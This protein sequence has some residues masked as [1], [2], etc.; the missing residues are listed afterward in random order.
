M[1]S[2]KSF[3]DGLDFYPYGV[4][5]HRA[6]TPLKTEWAGDMREISLAGYTHIQL[7]PQWKW[8]ERIHGKITW[9]DMDCL[10]DLAK[11]NNLRVVLKPM[12]ETAPDWVFS[13][14]DGTRMG[15][16]GIAIPPYSHSAYY[17]G[18]WWPCFDN[19]AVIDAATIFVKSLVE[20]Y[21]N[22]P[23]LWFYNAWNEPVSR[24]VGQCTCRYSV[25]SYRNWL[26]KN[27]GTVEEL[28]ERFGKAWTSYE[29]L[30]PPSSWEDYVEVFLWRKW[31]E[32]SVA[33]Q[34][35]FVADAIKSVNANAFVMTHVGGA[36]VV[37]D[38]MCATSNDILNAKKVDRYGTSF[39]VEL[40]PRTPLEH[41]QPDYLSDWLRRVD[42]KY[43][44]HEFYP[45]HANWCK[46]PD[47]PTLKRLVWMAIAGGPA[48]FTYWQYR[49]ERFGTESN[50]FGLRNIDGSKTDRSEVADSIGKMLERFGA[51]LKE[52][53]IPESQV[54]I[55]YDRDSDLVSRIQSSQ[56]FWKHGGLAA[57]KD[58]INYPYK[59]AIKAAHLMY[60]ACGIN[61]DW[62]ISYDELAGVKLLHITCDEMMNEQK[63]QWLG[64]F[65]NNG[66]NLVVE[67]PFACRDERTWITPQQP[68]F[69]L[70]AFLGC[71]EISRVISDAEHDVAKFDNGMEFVSR[72]WKIDI[73]PVTAKP[74]AFWQ[75]GKVAAVEN[76]FGKGKIYT[77]GVNVSLAFNNEWSYPGFN[78]FA[79][80][81]DDCGISR[82]KSLPRDVR[83]KKR[84][85]EKFD[86]YFIFNTSCEERK[87]HIS[88][89]P[90]EIWE[91]D[92][93]D[94]ENGMLTMCGG[95]TWIAKTWK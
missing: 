48:G 78:L 53:S 20:R 49:S 40:N 95:A 52:T 8:H 5:Y 24:P 19:P 45:N 69:M 43:W 76:R 63:A 34:V 80:F 28:N 57:E 4:Q 55:L 87:I 54:A 93:C 83:M 59:N 35:G 61:V 25:E 88:A 16:N 71:R 58:S 9:D 11:K 70:D 86:V 1:I 73:E 91:A 37:Q 60:N 18:G 23:A 2:N 74:V 31:A 3:E 90:A 75:D 10:F 41:D 26:K 46:P 44:C 84:C 12:L 22:H 65:V 38:P 33:S 51:D 89:K 13:E 17:V 77:L 81:L 6:P 94:F 56:S 32:E 82:I 47:K 39:W 92:G 21:R 42:S 50:G 66:G 36:S 62:K 27:F 68:G 30:Y 85:T 29:T 67:F 15:I 7:R 14:L 64:K 72:G 79:S